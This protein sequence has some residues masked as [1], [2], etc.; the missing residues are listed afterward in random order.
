M[1]F[2]RCW[3]TLGLL[4]C[5]PLCFAGRDELPSVFAPPQAP[6][7]F[8]TI[9]VGGHHRLSGAQEQKSTLEAQGFS[10]V[11]IQTSR[12]WNRVYVG[13]FD[14]CVDALICQNTLLAD[15]SL[16]VVRLATL[17]NTEGLEIGDNQAP[18]E[19]VFTIGVENLRDL[20]PRDF[21]DN[22]SYLNLEAMEAAG[23]PAWR[24]TCEAH[25]AQA[26]SDQ[27][28]CGYLHTRLGIDDLVNRRYDEAMAHC[29][30]VANGEVASD[31]LTRNTALRRVAW[32][33]RIQGERLRA[34]QAYREISQVTDLTD[35]RVRC[36]VECVS[37]IMELAQWDGIGSWAD[38]RPA[39]Q[40]AM[41][42]NPNQTPLQREFTCT[43]QLQ[44]METYMLDGDYETAVR[45][46][47]QTLQNFATM[48]GE[49]PVREYGALLYMAGNN[50]LE[51]GDEDRALGYYARVLNEVPEDADSFDRLHPHAEALNGLARIALRSRDPG[52]AMTV[53]RDLVRE[54]PNALIVRELRRAY[55]ELT[56]RSA[57]SE[58]GN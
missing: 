30:P 3:L 27:Q 51:L 13:R 50:C 12:G 46:C 22:P 24:A 41:Q 17:E 39:A 47:D 33:L 14:I 15:P 48:E 34:Y 6:S 9:L 20:P 2:S 7:E 58:E 53:Y 10:P 54:H 44:F 57:A 31:A 21:G 37:L 55:P 35:L 38:C 45:L 25:L 8:Y 18:I 23:D 32:L 52:T 11:F 42:N 43:L 28:I 4:G 29:L 56:D 36:D 19:P 40:R 1:M 5:V 49:P 16:S 26:S